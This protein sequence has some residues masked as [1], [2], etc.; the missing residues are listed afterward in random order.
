MQV[1]KIDCSVPV[2][3]K[4]MQTKVLE[5][6]LRTTLK[7]DGK[8]ANLGDQVRISCSKTVVSVASDLPMSKKYLKYLTKKF[9]KK[10]GARDWV[11]VVASSKDAYKVSIVGGGKLLLLGV[12][13]EGGVMSKRSD[14]YSMEIQYLRC[15]LP[16]LPRGLEHHHPLWWWW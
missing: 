12:Q 1:F 15:V 8:R 9:L 7:V 5:E 13:S 2:E 6:H 10:Y 16:D 14:Y 4:V 11:R 3:D